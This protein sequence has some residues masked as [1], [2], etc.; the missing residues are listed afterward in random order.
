MNTALARN[1]YFVKEHTGA[2]SNYDVLDPMTQEM[3]LTCREENLG[4]VAKVF[5]YSPFKRRTPFEV[6]VKTATGEPVI[7]V[8]RGT[9]LMFSNV[10]VLDEKS[11]R[12]GGFQEKFGMSASFEVVDADNQPVSEL[13][14]K[15][16]GRDFR[17][18]KEGEEL[19]RITQKYAG[20]AKE[21]FTSAD[22]YILE[23]SSHVPADS[24]LRMLIL[25]AV[26]CIDLVLKE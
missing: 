2:L 5:R 6:C 26:M 22:N 10:D 12:V 21:W 14:G 18:V 1:V 19:A 25:G 24:P 8:K 7:T 3:V 15:F 16:S 23:I 13:K 11:Q 4:G 17:F 20:F 9:A